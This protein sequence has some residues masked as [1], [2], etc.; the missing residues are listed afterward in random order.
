MLVV[1]NKLLNEPHL[2]NGVFI[3]D[4]HFFGNFPG[5]VYNLVGAHAKEL[6]QNQYRPLK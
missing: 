2:L 6:R 1:F 5:I 3:L 4:N